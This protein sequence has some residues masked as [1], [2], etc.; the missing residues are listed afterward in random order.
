MADNKRKNNG[1][2][3]RRNNNVDDDFNPRFRKIRKKGMCNVR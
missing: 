2:N 3:N 1:K